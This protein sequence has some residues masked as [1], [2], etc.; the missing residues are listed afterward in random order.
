MLEMF[1]KAA[2]LIIELE[3][4]RALMFRTVVFSPSNLVISILK[5]EKGGDY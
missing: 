5:S 1:P 2:L 3:G 4:K